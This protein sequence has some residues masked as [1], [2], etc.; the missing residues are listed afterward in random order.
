MQILMFQGI[1]RE[2]HGSLKKLALTFREHGHHTAALLCLDHFFT[3]L[4]DIRP[5]QLHEMA[6]FLETFHT[7]AQLLYQTSTMPDPLGRRECDVQRL[8]SVVS[9][10]G[11]E[12]LIPS[13]TFLYD[14]VTETSRNYRLVSMPQSGYKASRRDATELIHLSI[15][16]VLKD[17]ILELDKMCC[18]APVFLQR[19]PSVSWTCQREP[20]PQKQVAISSTD[21][22]QYN[23]H[24]AIHMQ[25]I[26]ILQ[27]LYSAHPRWARCAQCIVCG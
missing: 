10:P 7:Y 27:L 26:L 12:F 6:S 15:R 5:F 13:G 1:L 20:Y 17:K 4:T 8:L 3:Q 25:L 16:T 23:A 9:L 24:V 21:H 19:L 22:V 2:D 18:S 11:D 14:N